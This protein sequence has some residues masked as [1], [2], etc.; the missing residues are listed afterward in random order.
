[1]EEKK[2]KISARTAE[3]KLDLAEKHLQEARNLVY[4]VVHDFDPETLDE[5]LKADFKKRAE[6]FYDSF[7]PTQSALGIMNCCLAVDI[8]RKKRAKEAEKKTGLTKVAG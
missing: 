6:E 7:R 4:E 2:K 8:E 3:K 5:D 1:M